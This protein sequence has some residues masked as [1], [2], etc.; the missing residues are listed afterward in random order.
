MWNKHR[1]LAFMGRQRAGNLFGRK[2]QSTGCVKDELN[3]LIVRRQAYRAQYRFRV[4]DIDI[5]GYLNTENA[6]TFLTVY[7]RYNP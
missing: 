2:D 5:A 6:L 1:H 3:R 4:F 7:E